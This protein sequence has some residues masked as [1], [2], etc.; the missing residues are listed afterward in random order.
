MLISLG[1]P[2]YKAKSVHSELR[3]SGKRGGRGKQR[4]RG[5]ETF[6]DHFVVRVK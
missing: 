6:I 3:S 4:A 1:I 2:G 5:L